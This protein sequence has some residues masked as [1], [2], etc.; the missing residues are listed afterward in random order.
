MVKVITIMDD[1]YADLY[2]IKKGKDMSF[3]QVLRYLMAERRGGESGI[4][5]FAN[6]ISDA[7]IDSRAVYQIRNEHAWVR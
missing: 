3:S 6:S 7:D 5:N 4:K 2:R 1:V